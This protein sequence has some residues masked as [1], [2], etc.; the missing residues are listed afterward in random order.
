MLGVF[1]QT[2]VS[3]H[4]KKEN[5]PMW[6]KIIN[7]VK[8]NG[9]IVVTGLTMG[10]FAIVLRDETNSG[11]IVYFKCMLGYVSIKFLA[12]LLPDTKI[13]RIINGIISIPFIIAMLLMPFLQTILLTIFGFIVPFM[14][15]A[16]CFIK[17]P[18]IINIDLNKSTKI[19]LII[20]LSTIFIVL[21]SEKLMTIFNK[22]QHNFKP[23]EREKTQ[24]EFSKTLINKNIARFA[25]YLFY[26]IALII[27]S[28]STLNKIE[29]FN[30]KDF[31]SAILMSFATY[32]AF[33]RIINNINIM[34]FSMKDI[35][36]KYIEIIKTYKF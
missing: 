34:K 33:E 27:S 10:A 4:C 3:R 5:Q 32:I 13:F 23:I 28:V 1:A 9:F 30:S 11:F 16:C 2:L 19:Y 15:F 20:T 29:I 35:V 12:T 24:L 31:M 25:I 8:E 17:F 6:N 14:F 21:F 36:R 26:F 18:E 22:V 7:W